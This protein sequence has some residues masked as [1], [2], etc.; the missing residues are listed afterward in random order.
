MR[1]DYG[2]GTQSHLEKMVIL[3]KW[4]SALKAFLPVFYEDKK[5]VQE[6]NEK[7]SP[8]IEILSLSIEDMN[9]LYD[10]SYEGLGTCG[11]N[12]KTFLRAMR[13]VMEQADA[14]TAKAHVIDQIKSGD[15][16]GVNCG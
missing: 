12:E 15:E 7:I 16:D 9:Q 8:L 6:Y 13:S 2:R 11:Q 5:N 4:Y 1:L 14:I 10:P 3:E